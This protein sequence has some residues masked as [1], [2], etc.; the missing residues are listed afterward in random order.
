MSHLWELVQ[1]RGVRGVA[2]TAIQLP[3]GCWGSRGFAGIASCAASMSI[4]GG[5]GSASFSVPTPPSSQG[6]GTIPAVS[7]LGTPPCVTNLRAG[8]GHH[9]QRLLA[10]EQ[11]HLH[12]QGAC[13]DF[14][15]P[16]WLHAGTTDRV[17]I[18]PRRLGRYSSALCPLDWCTQSA[19]GERDMSLS[20][21]DANVCCS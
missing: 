6:S 8:F 16:A 11:A 21:T 13:P 14:N 19:A 9:A 15:P 20:S 18:P 17:Y 10:A 2:D 5:L 7:S 1:G 12:L 3:K 4:S